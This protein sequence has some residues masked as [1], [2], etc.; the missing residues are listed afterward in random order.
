M[1]KCKHDKGWVLIERVHV[2]IDQEGKAVFNFG[3]VN[4]YKKGD[5]KIGKAACNLTVQGCYAV[6]NVYLPKGIKARLGKIR[7][8]VGAMK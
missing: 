7:R 1:K 6:R 2:F 5:Y 4:R 3:N 8:V